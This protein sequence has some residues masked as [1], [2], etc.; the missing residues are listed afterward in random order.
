MRGEQHTPM[1]GDAP[2]EQ[3]SGVHPMLWHGGDVWWAKCPP[4][5]WGGCGVVLCSPP[6]A[7]EAAGCGVWCEA[8]G[9][10]SGEVGVCDAGSG[11]LQMAASD[12]REQPCCQLN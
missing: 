9:L 8:A 12:K 5:L 11:A 10:C 2:S 7:C 6:V 3:G 1:V 4:V